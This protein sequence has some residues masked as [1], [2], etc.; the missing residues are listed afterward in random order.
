PGRDQYASLLPDRPGRGTLARSH[1]PTAGGG[2]RREPA[3]RAAVGALRRAV[4]GPR[5]ERNLAPAPR[6]VGR[7]GA[8]GDGTR[9]DEPAAGETL[10]AAQGTRRHGRG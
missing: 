3:G 2:D 4:G 9:P 5:A 8:T 6:S 7:D 10:G 1:A